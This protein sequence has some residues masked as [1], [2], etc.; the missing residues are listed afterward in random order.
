MGVLDTH[1]GKYAHK[2]AQIDPL[3]WCVSRYFVCGYLS[4]DPFFFIPARPCI[5]PW[6]GGSEMHAYVCT[7][8]NEYLMHVSIARDGRT[9][10]VR[11]VGTNRIQT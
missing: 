3:H 6:C 2:Q 4:R 9:R 1:S 10:D 11:Q 8:S 5:E 7:W